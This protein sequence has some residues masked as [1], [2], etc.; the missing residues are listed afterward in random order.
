MIAVIPDPDALMADDRRQ[1]HLACQVD[2][3]LCNPEHDPSFAA[4]LYSATVAEFEAKEW[5]EYPPE[6]HGYPRE[7]Q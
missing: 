2:N 5:T 1:H 4:V 3:Y 7:D 6:G